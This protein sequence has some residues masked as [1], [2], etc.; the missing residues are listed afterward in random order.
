MNVYYEDCSAERPVERTRRRQPTVLA[1][2]GKARKP[3]GD[4]IADLSLRNFIGC[5]TR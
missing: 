1:A 5:A 4:A 2:Y 3:N